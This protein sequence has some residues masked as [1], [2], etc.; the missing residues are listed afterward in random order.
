M[1]RDAKDYLFRKYL[2]P[3][4]GVFL[5][6]FRLVFLLRLWRVTEPTKAET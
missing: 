2:E 4:L 6:V 3:F 1:L 5:F